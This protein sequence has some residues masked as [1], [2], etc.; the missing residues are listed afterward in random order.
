[1][2]ADNLRQNPAGPGAGGMTGHTLVPHLGP[3]RVQQQP[4]QLTHWVALAEWFSGPCVL[5]PG[6]EDGNP[7]LRLPGCWG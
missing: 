7:V 1:M 6:Y 3:L 2:T 4:I 5:P